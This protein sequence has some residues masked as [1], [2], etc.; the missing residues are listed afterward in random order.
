MEQVGIAR[1]DFLKG[2]AAAALTA[3]VIG[4]GEARALA[5]APAWSHKKDPPILPQTLQ[6]FPTVTGGRN[7]EEFWDKVRQTFVLPDNYIHMNTGTTGSQPLFSLI[8][9]GVYNLYKSMD[10][11]DWE[12]N[13]NNDFPDLFPVSANL[14][15]GT[16]TMPGKQR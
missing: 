10:P 8:N 14:V 7:T 5:A 13:L 11:R 15:L 6:P 2:I 3:G 16:R 9:L 1:R 4:T 12:S